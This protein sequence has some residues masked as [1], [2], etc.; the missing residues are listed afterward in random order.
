MKLL[1]CLTTF[2]QLFC[3]SYFFL[4]IKAFHICQ[5]RWLIPKFNSKATLRRHKSSLLLNRVNVFQSGNQCFFSY[6]NKCTQPTSRFSCPLIFSHPIIL[7]NHTKQHNKWAKFHVMMMKYLLI[8]K[9]RKQNVLKTCRGGRAVSPGVEEMFGE[10]KRVKQLVD[11]GLEKQMR[12]HD[13]T[14]QH[15][16]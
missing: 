2:A 6:H 3:L 13:S 9:K 16:I 8:D 14:H 15:M 12:A 4:L 11:H 7:V 10:T 5:K 1:Y